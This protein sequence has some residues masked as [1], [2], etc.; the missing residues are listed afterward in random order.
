MELIEIAVSEGE[1]TETAPVRVVT[2]WFTKE[3][4][5]IARRDPL[6]DQPAVSPGAPS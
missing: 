3:G 6:A 4:V 2:Y 5:Q 1:G